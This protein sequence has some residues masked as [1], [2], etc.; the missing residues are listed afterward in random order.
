MKFFKTIDPS[1]TRSIFHS[2]HGMVKYEL[3]YLYWI[4]K[5][6]KN[7]YKQRYIDGCSKCSTK[8]LSMLRTKILTAVKGKLQTYC[9]TA[10]ARSGVNLMWII[11]NSK[12]LLATLKAQNFFQIN[13]IKT[14]DLSTL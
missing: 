1:Y 7:P 2:M 6:Y 9:G 3:L 11:K 13:S 14:Y 10:Y 5:L 12:K 8:P 4:P